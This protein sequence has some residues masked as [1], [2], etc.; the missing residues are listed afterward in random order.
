MTS[1]EGS[2]LGFLFNDHLSYLYIFLIC[3]F[4]VSRVLVLVSLFSLIDDLPTG[5]D[6]SGGQG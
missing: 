6:E 4:M 3:D 2:H 1:P 5:V